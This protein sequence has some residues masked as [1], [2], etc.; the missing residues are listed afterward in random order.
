[1][2]KRSEAVALMLPVSSRVQNQHQ[3]ILKAQPGTY[4]L[5][6][7]SSVPALI[8]VG[9]L[10]S[11][12]LHPGFYTYVGSAHGPGGSAPGSRIIWGQAAA[13]TGTLTT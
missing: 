2:R 12:R 7:S 8:R 3:P 1:M 10:G 13:P 11:L 4:A 9:R 5:V 6:L